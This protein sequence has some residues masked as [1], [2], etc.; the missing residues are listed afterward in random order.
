MLIELRKSEVLRGH[1]VDTKEFEN[2]ADVLDSVFYVDL[3]V[4]LKGVFLV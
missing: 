3:F 2:G 4:H 1:I